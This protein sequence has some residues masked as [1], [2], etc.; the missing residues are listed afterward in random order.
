MM[1]E[2]VET[3]AKECERRRALAEANAKQRRREREEPG[4]KWFVVQCVGV[5]DKQV[6]HALA[7]YDV[8]T[9]V[10]RTIVMKPVPRRRMSR[11][12]RLSGH[13]IEVPTEAPLFPRYV[14]VQVDTSRPGWGH[15]FTS[16]GVGGL[17]CNEG[18]PVFMSEKEMA[19]VRS[20][21]ND[22]VIPGDISLMEL[23]NVGDEVKVTDGPFRDFD[24]VVDRAFE[25]PVKDLDPNSQIRVAI[26]MFGRVTSVELAYWQV[27]KASN[28]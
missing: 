19:Y 25:A 1:D 20:L 18:R 6:I 15:V 21:E 7:R 16:P 11:Q 9:Y 2:I 12:Q 5:S 17:V 3:S 22:G 27:K 4:P 13:T 28:S 26:P 24:A 8:E 14:F 10:P 23:F